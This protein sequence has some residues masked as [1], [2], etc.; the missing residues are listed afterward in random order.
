M[1]STRRSYIAVTIVLVCFFVV[2]FFVYNA[3]TSPTGIKARLTSDIHTLNT[4]EQTPY[5]N[6]DGTVTELAVS[7][8]EI[9]I[10]N[11][12]ATWSPYTGA[13]FTILK[14]FKETFG[15]TVRIIAL[16]RMEPKET[17][18]A[19]LETIEQ[20]T[21]I[22]FLLDQDDYFFKTV[23][24]YA[25]PET[26]VFDSIGNIIFHKRGTLQKDELETTVREI[27]AE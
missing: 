26:I 19:Y 18:Q 20:P 21:G 27:L 11:V 17:V 25:M 3:Y 1:Q 12:W 13:D 5:T 14:Q 10:V 4:E 16:N 24:G 15:D 6:L 23:G 8:E 7:G 22:E 9:L 2:I